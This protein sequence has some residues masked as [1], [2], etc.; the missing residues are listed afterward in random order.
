MQINNDIKMPH[1]VHEYA[2]F[3]VVKLIFIYPKETFFIF[4]LPQGFYSIM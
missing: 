3:L 2:A 4:T 1:P